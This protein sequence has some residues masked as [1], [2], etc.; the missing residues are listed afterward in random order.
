MFIG[1][2][3]A[4]VTNVLVTSQQLVKTD[5]EASAF[6][7]SNPQNHFRNNVASGKKKNNKRLKK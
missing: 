6:W 7:I 3:A 5:N 1:N 4:L 2:L